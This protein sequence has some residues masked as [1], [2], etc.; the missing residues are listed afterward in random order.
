[1]SWISSTDAATP[2][3]AVLGVRPELL[4]R[5]RAFYEQLWRDELVPRRVLELCRLRIAAIHDCDAEWVVRDTAV[6]VSEREHD[7]LEKGE[8]S[9]LSADERAALTVAEQIPYGHHQISDA[10]VQGLEKA[11]GAP[12][13]VSLLTALAFFDV[14]CRLKITLGVAALPAALID[15]PLLNNALV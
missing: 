1:M 8:F 14:T 4:S 11:F 12:G 13:A 7:A 15:P 6:S 5:Y 3:E 10:D 2:W 9:G